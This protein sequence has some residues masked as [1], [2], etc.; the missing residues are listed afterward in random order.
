[1]NCNAASA[2]TLYWIVLKYSDCISMKLHQ[3]VAIAG[4]FNCG[5]TLFSLWSQLY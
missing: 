4:K 5:C 1:M 2:D 3:V